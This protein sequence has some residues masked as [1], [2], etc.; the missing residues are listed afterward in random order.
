MAAKIFLNSRLTRIQKKLAKS[1]YKFR[2]ASSTVACCSH[3]VQNVLKNRKYI[4]IAVL[5]GFP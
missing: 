1:S 2:N 5:L 4:D 3:E